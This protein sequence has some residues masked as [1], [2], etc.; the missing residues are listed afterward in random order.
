MTAS[1]HVLYMYYMSLC[2]YYM[3]LCMY[4]MSL[5]MYYMSLCMYYM[6]LCMYVFM[7]VFIYV[8]MIDSI[9]HRYDV[10]SDSYVNQDGIDERIDK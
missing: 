2:M 8:C 6:S 4:Y 5:C 10:V 3:S 9:V 1:L 7:H